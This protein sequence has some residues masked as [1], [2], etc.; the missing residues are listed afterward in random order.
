MMMIWC[1]YISFSIIFMP[2]ECR[3]DKNSML[4]AGVT[5]IKDLYESVPSISILSQVPNERAK[6]QV[7]NLQSSVWFGFN[8]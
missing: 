6:L 7:L 8:I 5:K 1:F 4:Q 3:H 2:K